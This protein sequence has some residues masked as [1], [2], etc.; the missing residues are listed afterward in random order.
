MARSRFSNWAD[1]LWSIHLTIAACSAL[2]FS[3]VATRAMGILTR[4]EK[5]EISSLPPCV[6]PDGTASF[7]SGLLFDLR[8]LYCQCPR[9]F[10]SEISSG[11]ESIKFARLNSKLWCIRRISGQ[12]KPKAQIWF[13]N[14]R[15]P[16]RF[17]RWTTQAPPGMQLRQF[18]LC[19]SESNIRLALILHQRDSL[20]MW[21]N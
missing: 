8:H 3:S 15:K 10:R 4:G 18:L 12:Q 21:R 17:R 20:C 1:R 9:R 7:V 5:T 2:I 11:A 16:C 19:E 6:D 14:W 13:I